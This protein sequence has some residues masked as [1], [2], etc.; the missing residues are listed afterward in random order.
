MRRL[1]AMLLLASLAAC[2]TA[3]AANGYAPPSEEVVEAH[4]RPLR[5]KPPR[6][7]ARFLAHPS[8]LAAAGAAKALAEH[9]SQALPLVR[10]LLEDSHPAMR[11]GALK[12][13]AILFA[14]KPDETY[15]PGER[16][17][18]PALREMLAL[19]ATL[20]DD[21]ASQVQL[22]LG[23]IV[24]TLGVETPAVHKILF[25]MADSPDPAVRAQALNIGRHKI[26]DKAAKAR[27]G[28]LVSQAPEGNT[29][30]HWDLAHLLLQQGIEH[31]KPAIGGLGKFFGEDAPTLRRMFS[32][33]A[34]FRA[35][36]VIERYLDD[37][38]EGVPGLVPGLSICYVRVPR[39]G[40]P[41]W[42][43]YEKQLKRVLERMG[44]AAA[45]GMRAAIDAQRKWLAAATEKELKSLET[46][47]E[48][49]EK[50][51]EAL[52]ALLAAKRQAKP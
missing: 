18:T 1:P 11:A 38:L 24:G 37:G 17:V 26:Q 6:E 39:H 47:Q 7:I 20:V 8:D 33:G 41:G 40:Y 22:G 13:I 21:D 34:Q 52:E 23:T 45:P 12:T 2:T 4:A 14:P 42:V 5:G 48:Y 36:D 10:K 30:R 31:A 15:K 29:A 44:P 16:P 27:I 25:T 35:L 3:V 19:A 51:L 43:R 28:M 32:D 49:C 50:A 46:N 9:G